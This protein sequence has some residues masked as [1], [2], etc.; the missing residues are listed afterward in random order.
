MATMR[1]TRDEIQRHHYTHADDLGASWWRVSQP[2][3]EEIA[4]TCVSVVRVTWLPDRSSL[5]EEV[6]LGA[7]VAGADVLSAWNDWTPL[8][9]DACDAVPWP[10]VMPRPPAVRM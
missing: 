9:A 6:Y 1:P 5:R 10:V 8:D 7:T 4:A 2:T 3:R